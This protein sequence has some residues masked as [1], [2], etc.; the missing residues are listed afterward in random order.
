MRHGIRGQ[1]TNGR[2]QQEA[3]SLQRTANLSY[4]FGVIGHR[5][6]SRGHRGKRAERD[7]RSSETGMKVRA[8]RSEIGAHSSYPLLVSVHPETRFSVV[9]L[10]SKATKNLVAIGVAGDSS[11]RSE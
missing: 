3:D 10:R 6:W 11:L 4:G 1:R 9:I 2:G 5:A 8:R 7:E